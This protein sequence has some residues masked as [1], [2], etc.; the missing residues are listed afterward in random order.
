MWGC[1]QAGMHG[2]G[3]VQLDREDD[4][5]A[6]ALTPHRA[7][8]C[9]CRYDNEWG[10][11]NRLVDLCVL[12]RGLRPRVGTFGSQAAWDVLPKRD[13]LLNEN[14]SGQHVQL[15]ER[16]RRFSTSLRVSASNLRSVMVVRSMALLSVTKLGPHGEDGR[17]RV[18]SCMRRLRG[19]SDLQMIQMA[20]SCPLELVRFAN[21]A[22][23]SCLHERAKVNAELV[24]AVRTN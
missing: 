16:D 18:G 15:C 4:K 19:S 5:L 6:D 10:Y 7:R 9:A 1:R 14:R 8:P 3:A 21:S 12:M 23:V 20:K 2:L 24:G 17:Q 13:L 11:S 22:R